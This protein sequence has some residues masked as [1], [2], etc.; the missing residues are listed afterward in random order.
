MDSFHLHPSPREKL[1]LVFIIITVLQW[2]PAPQAYLFTFGFSSQGEF[3]EAVADDQ[4]LHERKVVMDLEYLHK[5]VDGL[6]L[7]LTVRRFPYA[8][9]AKIIAFYDNNFMHEGVGL[10][11]A[12][13]YTGPTQ[14]A[15]PFS[16]LLVGLGLGRLLLLLCCYFAAA[17]LAALLAALW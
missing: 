12:L 3:D 5:A 6:Y 7:P 15:I 13:P 16:H 4:D 8:K 14:Y 2:R 10:K 1:I 11:V 17:L 9:D